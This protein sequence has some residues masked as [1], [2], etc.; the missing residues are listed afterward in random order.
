MNFY[1]E[2]EEQGVSLRVHNIRTAYGYWMLN[3]TAWKE[4]GRSLESFYVRPE[5]LT[6]EEVLEC[7][8]REAL[9]TFFGQTYSVI[10]VDKSVDKVVL[11]EGAAV[12]L[13][14]GKLDTDR[15]VGYMDNDT[16]IGQEKPKEKVKHIKKKARK[17]RKTTAKKPEPEPVVDEPKD[18]E[19]LAIIRPTV[20]YD[21][22]NELLKEALQ[23]HLIEKFGS[24]WRNDAAKKLRV[25]ALAKRLKRTKVFYEDTLELTVEGSEVI[26]GWV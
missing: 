23:P 9:A 21:P 11:E 18:D 1:K 12:K 24:D 6:L 13:E 15:P 22:T 14:V 16:Q 25:I 17:P 4:G 10:S 7:C 20:E 19:I 8:K 3:I 26:N 5:N 2:A